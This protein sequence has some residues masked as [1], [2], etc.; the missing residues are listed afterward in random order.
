MMEKESAGGVQLAGDGGLCV[1]PRV[2]LRWGFP[3]AH[4]DRDQ[5]PSSRVSTV[6]KL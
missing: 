1:T 3:F 5:F 2:P 6:S 4:D